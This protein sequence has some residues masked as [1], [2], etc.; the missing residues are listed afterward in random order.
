MFFNSISIY[1]IPFLCIIL[2]LIIGLSNHTQNIFQ[3]Q[4]NAKRKRRHSKNSYT[5]IPINPIVITRIPLEDDEEFM[6]SDISSSFCENNSI[7]LRLEQDLDS[8]NLS[9]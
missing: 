7:E 6:K 5:T 2:I 1:S 8:D 4:F 3:Y 9:S